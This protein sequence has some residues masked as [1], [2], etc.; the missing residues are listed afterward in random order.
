LL[1]DAPLSVRRAGRTWSPQNSDRAFR[2]WVTARQ[3]LE[4]SLNVPT[5]RL[6]MQVGL[7]RVVDVARA[8]GIESRLQAVPA[9]ALGAFEVSPLELAAVYSVFAAGGMRV[10]VHGLSAVLDSE[11][12]PLPG[13]ALAEPVRAL[14]PQANYL[15]VSTLQGVIE[16]GTGASARIQ[17]VTDPLAGKTGTTNGRRDSWFGGFSPDRAT[18]VWVGYDDNSKTRLS[19][20]RA[21]LPVWARFTWSVRPRDGYPVFRQPRGIATAAIDPLSGELATD[22]CPKVL[23]EVF[24]E[25]AVPTRVCHLHAGW[26]RDDAGAEGGKKRWRWLKRVFGRDK[27]KDE[28]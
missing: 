17:G 4:E 18:L 22:D 12:K 25:G 14:S 27:K 6:A 26:S 11:G 19:G 24:L 5:A 2:G 21:A 3:A 23:T 28:G 20:A 15:V 9:L 7:A 1:E 13:G 8:L 16:R 10:P